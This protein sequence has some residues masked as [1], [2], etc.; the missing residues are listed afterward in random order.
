MKGVDENSVRLLQQGNVKGVY[1]AQNTHPETWSGKRVAIDHLAWKAK[2]DSKLPN[3]IFKKI[4]KW[5]K[6]LQAKLFG[7]AT[8][9]VM[10]LDGDGLLGFCPTTLDDIGVDGALTK[11]GN[12]YALCLQDLGL[13]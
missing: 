7:Q 3:L 6:Q 9:V 12:G 2:R 10:A 13:L 1:G 5:L 8:H 4:T 11:K